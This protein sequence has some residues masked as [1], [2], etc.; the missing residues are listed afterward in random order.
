MVG[1]GTYM[2]HFLSV[3]VLT[4]VLL[5]CKTCEF[6]KM[7]MRDEGGEILKDDIL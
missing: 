5:C 7:E 4:S 6:E 1:A 2:S 3:Q